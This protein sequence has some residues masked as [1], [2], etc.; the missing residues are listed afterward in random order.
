MTLD[1]CLIVSVDFDVD[2]FSSISIRP[3]YFVVC[4]YRFTH[5]E[6]DYRSL[7]SSPLLKSDKF[8]TS[9]RQ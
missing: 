7:Q 9:D 3:F 8:M 5:A 6:I 1:N 4:N 2:H